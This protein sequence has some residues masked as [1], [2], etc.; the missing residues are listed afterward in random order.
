MIAPSEEGPLALQHEE[1]HLLKVQIVRAVGVRPGNLYATCCVG[2]RPHVGITTDVKKDPQEPIWMHMGDLRDYIMGEFLEF[3]VISEKE[4]KV[5]EKSNRFMTNRMNSN[6]S[7]GSGRGGRQSRTTTSSA[8]STIIK[9]LLRSNSDGGTGS[10]EIPSSPGRK[11]NDIGPTL[12]SE[13][14]GSCTLDSSS[15]ESGGFEGKLELDSDDGIPAF[16]DVKVLVVSYPPPPEDAKRLFVKVSQGSELP[17]IEGNAF[18][19]VS[20]P[21]REGEMV[22]R[23]G[24]HQLS[25]PMWNE[26][27]DIAGYQPG[28]SLK[29]EIFDYVAGGSAASSNHKCVATADL[30]GSF[31]PAGYEGPLPLKCLGSD[32]GGEGAVLEIEVEIFTPPPQ[33]PGKHVTLEDRQPVPFQLR[34]LET[35]RLHKLCAYT[36]VGRSRRELDPT[37]DLVLDNP[38]IQDV[39]RQHAIVKAW[40]GADASSW[41][42]RCYS[43]SVFEGYGQS[44]SG[45]HAGG[46]TCVDGR[47]VMDYIGSPLEPTSV[48]RFGLRELWVLERTAVLARS[49]AAEV[50]CARARRM[51][52]DDPMLRRQ[53]PVGTL[54]VLSALREC[55]DWTS[56]V[57]VCLESIGEQDEPPCADAISVKDE[58][59]SLVRKH[60]AETIEEQEAFDVERELKGGIVLGASLELRLS[61]DPRL[62]GPLLQHLDLEREKL[63]DDKGRELDGVLL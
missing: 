4:E 27:N 9:T 17:Y 57:R 59:G 16:L 22:T 18:C 60:V 21:G 61:S 51:E 1:R 50:A 23:I 45:G 11:P 29:F 7:M 10:R 28:D 33:D 31:Y 62:L 15:F 40:Q 8:G 34:S 42:V 55:A 36:Q 47:P 32:E 24:G 49:Q 54:T 46:G 3:K 20:V 52:E 12:V 41:H 48:L 53:V 37:L 5:K 38:G 25:D 63:A 39:S 43:T 13:L 19:R 14:L 30:G 26:E 6:A 2:G 58:C 56:I 44:E 35:G